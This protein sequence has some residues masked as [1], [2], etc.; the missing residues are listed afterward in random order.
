MMRRRCELALEQ[1]WKPDVNEPTRKARATREEAADAQP[2][3]AKQ[4][5]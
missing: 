2:A 5:L 1:G 3:R 4:E